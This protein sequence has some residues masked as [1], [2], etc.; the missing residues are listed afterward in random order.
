MLLH[1]GCVQISFQ[2]FWFLG[3]GQFQ[4]FFIGQSFGF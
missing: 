1:I 2:V 3:F 4:D